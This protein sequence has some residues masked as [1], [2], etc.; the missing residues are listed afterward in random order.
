MVSALRKIL[1]KDADDDKEE[2]TISSPSPPRVSSRIEAND[3]GF[4]ELVLEEFDDNNNSE[5][6][7][8]SPSS[9]DNIPDGAFGLR[10][11]KSTPNGGGGDTTSSLF[12]SVSLKR[13][14]FSHDSSRSAHMVQDNIEEDESPLFLDH[15][16]K[17]KGRF[18]KFRSGAG[19]LEKEGDDNTVTESIDSDMEPNKFNKK[20]KNTRINLKFTLLAITMLVFAGGLGL[21]ICYALYPSLF[22]ESSTNEFPS[23]YVYDDGTTSTHEHSHPNSDD[24]GANAIKEPILEVTTSTQNS[25]SITFYAMADAPYTD[26]ERA[27]IMPQQIAN[28]KK[29]SGAEFVAHLGDLSYAR[30]DY[31]EERVFQNASEILKQSS[32]PVFVLPGDNDIND[33]ETMEH[34]KAMWTKYFSPLTN[35]WTHKFKMIRW[36]EVNES[37][38]FIHNRVLF[39]GLNII[40]GSPANWTETRTR[41]EEHL[42]KLNDIMSVHDDDYEMIVL[43]AHASP[44]PVKHGDFFQG[45]KLNKLQ[46]IHSFT[47]L[48]KK[49]GQPVLHLHGD[50][51]EWARTDNAYGIDNYLMICLDAGEIAPP[52]KVN[53][54][55]SKAADN[56][57]RIERVKAVKPEGWVNLLSRGTDDEYADD[58][59]FVVD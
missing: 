9:N 17:K 53:I 49:S 48:V 25:T 52:I 50:D 56:M 46:G 16:K 38:A 11:F 13:S 55:T 41:H 59:E 51:H 1:S 40:G 43:F 12:K 54:D 31:C 20:K 3:E 34:G 47:D 32:L 4:T 19:T 5:S 36:G 39:L 15:K 2:D 10:R 42:T 24:S 29:E 44:D 35:L 8:L 58:D 30:V 37:F 28:L 14:I 26:Y 6:R 45:S 33:C 27:H 7:P 23:N 21:A 18:T 22:N 57:I